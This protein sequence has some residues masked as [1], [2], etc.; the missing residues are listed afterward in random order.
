[1]FSTHFAKVHSAF[2]NFIITFVGVV[3]VDGRSGAG[4]G[5]AGG[6]F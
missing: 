6:W 4:V 1:M 5:A 3:R 2:K